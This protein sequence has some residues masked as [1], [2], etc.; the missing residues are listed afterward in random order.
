[1]FSLPLTFSLWLSPSDV[2]SPYM[3]PLESM[4]AWHQTVS[5]QKKVVDE[6][7]AGDF[8]GEARAAILKYFDVEAEAAVSTQ[9]KFLNNYTDTMAACVEVMD[10]TIAGGTL[11]FE[12]LLEEAGPTLPGEQLYSLTKTK[13]AREFHGTYKRFNLAKRIP[14]LVTSHLLESVQIEHRQFKDMVNQKIGA[15]N[16]LVALM[17]CVQGI[18]RKPQDGVTRASLVE[19]AVAGLAH[20]NIDLPP[21]TGAAKL[22]ILMSQ[23]RAGKA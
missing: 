18:F 14:E 13:E 21:R 3:C 19:A 12:Q 6:E 5:Q 16:D 17:T 7:L 1:M 20:F 4:T 22:K 10:K 23:Q 9:T 15:I 8:N 11:N 2:R